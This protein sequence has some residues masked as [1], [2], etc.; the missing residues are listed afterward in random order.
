MRNQ[1]SAISN[2]Q[3][4][5]PKWPH[6]QEP[7]DMPDRTGQQGRLFGI[8]G[9]RN[10]RYPITNERSVLSAVSVSTSGGASMRCQSGISDEAL[11]HFGEPYQE[12][13]SKEDIFYYIYGLLHSE[14]YR[15][16]YADNLRRQL[17]RI[18]RMRRYADFKA[19][20]KAGREL[21]EMH[22]NYE[23]VPLY[24]HVKL[25]GVVGQHL[26][27]TEQRIEGGIDSNFYV[28]KM[29][30]GP[31]KDKRK[32]IYNTAITVED[33]PEDAYAYVV[34]GKSAIAW[35]MDRQK[36]R[37]DKTSGIENDANDYAKEIGNPRYPLELLLRIITLSLKTQKIVKALP[38]L[39]IYEGDLEDASK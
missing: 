6:S 15:Q 24:Q 38:G 3:F 10:S 12:S 7:I 39:D 37:V 23:Q 4:Y 8:D 19:F 35:I 34:N 28:E 5:T 36:V 32:I 29:K 2:Q 20:S 11:A 31:G 26:Y 1:Q 14:E 17:P 22:V 27:I 18:P 21:G 30:F 13:I 25:T 33:I 16:R 9:G